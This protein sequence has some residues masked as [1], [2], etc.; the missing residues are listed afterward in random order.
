MRIYK[1]DAKR[2][3]MGSKKST[4]RLIFLLT[5]FCDIYDHC[6][7]SEEQLGEMIDVRSRQTV[8]DASKEIMAKGLFKKTT[9]GMKYLGGDG[10]QKVTN[11]YRFPE[12]YVRRGRYYQENVVVTAFNIERIYLHALTRLCRDDEL[13][14]VLTRRE[15][16]E[17]M[18]IRKEEAAKAD[19]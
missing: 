11:K 3:L 6:G 15:Y 16:A 4:R 5:V 12:D 8:I 17:V 10:L 13:K 7:L 2:I 9:G 14:D 1:S 19:G 18:R